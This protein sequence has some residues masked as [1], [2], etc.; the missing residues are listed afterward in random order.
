VTRYFLG[1]DIGGTKSHALLADETGEAIALGTNGAGNHESVG[2]EQMVNVMQSIIDQAL[3]AAGISLDQISGA[4]FG[5][6]GYDWISERDIMLASIARTGIDCPL[7]VVNDTLIGLVAGATEGWGVAVVSGTG[8]N[9]WGWDK[10]R[11]IGRVTGN[12]T[13]MA[14]GAGGTELTEKAIQAVSLEWSRRGKPTSITRE[15][16]K[17]CGAKD[18]TDLMEGLC[19]GVYHIDASFAPVIFKCA[20]DGDAVAREVIC[21]AGKQ[22]ASMAIGVI[23]QLGVEPLEFEMILVGSMYDGGAILIDP[24]TELIHSVAPRAKLLRLNTLP[25]VGG[26]LLGMDAIGKRMPGVHSRLIETTRRL[27]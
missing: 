19:M 10:K 26:V 25:A 12:G 3:T 18:V 1:V 16:I 13:W 27:R 15:L 22:L 6:A 17:V 20:E 23:H 9:C 7:E 8:C 24:M 5:I 11:R 2:Y 21:W 14:E 4:G